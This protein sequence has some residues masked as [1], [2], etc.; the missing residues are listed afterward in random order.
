MRGFTA[1]AEEIEPSCLFSLVSALLA[2]QVQIIHEFGGYVDKFGGDGVVSFF[3][4]PDMVL[5]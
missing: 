4:G 2:D 5:H 3:E 1:F